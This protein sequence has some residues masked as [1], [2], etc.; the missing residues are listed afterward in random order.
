[1][2]EVR[3]KAESRERTEMTLA[4]QDHPDALLLAG[5]LAALTAMGTKVVR[6]IRR[7]HDRAQS[8]AVN[9]DRAGNDDVSQ[10]D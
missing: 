2:D 3:D 10:G 5:L 9:P 1:M 4:F 7:R 8:E 6:M